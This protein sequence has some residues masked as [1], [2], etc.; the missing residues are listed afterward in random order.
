MSH[1]KVSVSLSKMSWMLFLLSRVKIPLIGYVNPRIVSLDDDR[2]EVRIKLR[3][4]TKN[5]LNSMYFGALAVGA[6]LSAGIHVFYF[7]K[8]YD[9]RISFAFKSMHAQFIQRAESHVT[10]EFTEGR[11]VEDLVLKSMETLERYNMMTEV[12]A[13]NEARELVAKFEMEISLKVFK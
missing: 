5:H 1:S 3:R 10:F 13:Y 8:K 7:M 2:V 6:D 12:R 11:Q 4:R 9:K